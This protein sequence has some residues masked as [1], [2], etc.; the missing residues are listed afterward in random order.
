MAAEAGEDRR[1]AEAGLPLDWLSRQGWREANG[2]PAVYQVHKYWARRPGSLFRALI[3]G[4]LLPA[5][6]D[7]ESVCQHGSPALA[8]RIVLDPFMGGGT[9]I[10]EALRLG[11]RAVGV[12]LNPLAW[13][14]TGRTVTA[15]D[16]EEL[17][18]AARQLAAS[19]GAA[20]RA[21]YR[22]GC[23]GCGGEADT[24]YAF[25]VRLAACRS[26]GRPCDL[27]TSRRLGPGG[28]LAVCPGCGD[29]GPAGAPC[30]GCGLAADPDRT[31]ARRGAFTCPACGCSQRT[32]DAAGA[33]GAPLPLRLYALEYHCPGCGQRG[34]KAPAP[35]D[36]AQVAAARQ[37]LSRRGQ[38][39]PLPRA[40]VPDGVKTRDLLRHG[41]RTWDQLFGPRQLLSLGELL[42]AIVRLPPGPVR[43]LLLVTFS[44]SLNANN[45]LCKYNRA[46]GKLEPLFGLHAYHIVDQPVENNVWG[47]RV[48]RGSFRNYLAKARRAQAAL[49]A[50]GRPAADFASLAAGHGNVLLRCAG[51]HRLDFLPDGAVDAVITDPPYFDNVQY[52]ELSRFFT[53]WLEV[54]LGS[55]LPAFQPGAELVV[56]R[57]RGGA[58]YGHGL[59]AA[60]RECRRVLRPG[61]LL[62]FTFHHRAPAAWAALAQAVGEAGFQ[63]VRSYPV[64]AEARSGLHSAA[65]NIKRDQ[66][67]V[68]RR[69]AGG[70]PAPDWPALR[71]EMLAAAAGALAAA[72]DLPRVEGEALALGAALAPYT[73][74]WPPPLAPPAALAEV[75]AAVRG[76]LARRPAP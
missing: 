70:T 48:G 35:R 1:A 36:L 6:T 26:C 2:R 65:G 39:L 32:L 50:P 29:V 34:W 37:E 14:I 22:T 27:F 67:F 43:D 75:A 46:A 5:G 64:R 76:W 66:A 56:A 71:R 3:A 16:P 17:A 49:V 60:F 42:A 10:V 13:Y 47:A 19:P 4:A 20:I 51:A 33:A 11:C 30:R 45:L 41:Y 52:G 18:A 57:G 31:G 8:G 15:V 9:T 25:W 21:R 68:C 72:G 44:D 53:A 61:G 7:L 74:A 69:A 28:R 63:V 62:V 54:A 59:A 23:P 12:D 73:R 24:V 38:G 55:D 58:R 40:P